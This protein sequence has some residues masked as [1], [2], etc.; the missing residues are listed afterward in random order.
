MSG[1]PSFYS[2]G[3]CHAAVRDGTSVQ[4]YR[5]GA[6][7]GIAK[8]LPAN[9]TPDFVNRRPITM[10]NRS[11]ISPGEGYAGHCSLGLVWNRP[12]DAAAM[13]RVFLN[14]NALFVDGTGRIVTHRAF[15]IAD[16]GGGGGGGADINQ[17]ART[18][19]LLHAA[20]R[21]YARR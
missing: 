21:A 3:T 4:F 18:R 20:H 8:T 15:G 13:K 7:Y 14:P 6:T 5:D 16:S 12:L 2:A 9:F 11:E 19:H 1:D 17:S 10:M